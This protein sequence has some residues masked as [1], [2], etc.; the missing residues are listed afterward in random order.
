MVDIKLLCFTFF[1]GWSQF[2]PPS[3]SWPFGS[4][5][6]AFRTLLSLEYPSLIKVRIILP[7]RQGSSQRF[8]VSN[9]LGQTNDPDSAWCKSRNLSASALILSSAGTA[10]SPNSANCHTADVHFGR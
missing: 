4:Q 3:S 1:S 5:S 8:P 9:L 7:V 6:I 10:S 2:Q